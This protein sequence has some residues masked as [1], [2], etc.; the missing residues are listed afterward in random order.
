M[1]WRTIAFM[2]IDHISKTIAENR[3]IIHNII[4]YT[5]KL[6]DRIKELEDKKND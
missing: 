6:E 4:K 3:A 1:R 2:R 5:F